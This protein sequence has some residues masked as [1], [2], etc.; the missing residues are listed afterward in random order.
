M[1]VGFAWRSGRKSGERSLADSRIEHWKA[2]FR[3]AGVHWICLQYDDC[4]E[5][6]GRARRQFGV[7]L[8]RFDD[9]DFFDDL[10]EVA[11]LNTGLDLVIARRSAVSLLSAALGVQ[12]WEFHFGADWQAHGTDGNPWLPAATRF[13]RAWDCTWEA[14]FER[15]AESLQARLAP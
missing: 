6:L 15:L 2:L 7:A 4:E 8:H 10:D 9:V 11:A 1:K 13:K 12:T 5:E 14:F 3:L